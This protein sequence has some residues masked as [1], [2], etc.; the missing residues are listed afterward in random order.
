MNINEHMQICCKYV[1][2]VH[3]ETTW[4]T[5]KVVSRKLIEGSIITR[6]IA[7][8][9]SY[10]DILESRSKRLV[11]CFFRLNWEEKHINSLQAFIFS[12]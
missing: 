4:L 7:L 2:I 9:R 11:G 10:A 12:T 6:I 8:W 1:L 5:T 3:S